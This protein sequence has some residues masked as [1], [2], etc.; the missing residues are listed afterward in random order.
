[1]NDS[2]SENLLFGKIEKNQ[3]IIFFTSIF[4]FIICFIIL[5]FQ[6]YGWLRYGI[7]TKLPIIKFIPSQVTEYFYSTNDWIGLKKILLSFLD[8]PL[9]F[10]FFI[11][12]CLVSFKLKTP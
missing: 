12:G 6:C 8:I 5:L 3:K 4:F 10:L 1:M 2:N 11:L 9:S 7:W